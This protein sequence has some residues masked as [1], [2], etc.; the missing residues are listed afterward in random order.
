MTLLDPSHYDPAP[1]LLMDTVHFPEVLAVPERRAVE[2]GDLLTFRFA[3]GYGAAVTRM[4]GC[5]LLHAFEFCVLDCTPFQPQ[6]TSPTPLSRPGFC[7][8]SRA[9]K[10]RR[11]SSRPSVSPATPA[12][13]RPT[14][15]WASRI[16]E[17]A[18]RPEAAHPNT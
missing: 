10:S 16:S 13:S 4:D 2:G 15:G 12:S 6:P 1:L 17:P 9:R 18:F 5:A 3:N 11:C 14:S 7:P 8:E